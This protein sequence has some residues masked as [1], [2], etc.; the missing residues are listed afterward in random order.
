MQW[1]PG[2]FRFEAVAQASSLV[3]CA[4]KTSKRGRLLHE[5]MYFPDCPSVL[6]IRFRHGSLIL[7]IGIPEPIE[8]SADGRQVIDV[9]RVVGHLQLR[10]D[11]GHI[12]RGV[13]VGDPLGEHRAE[14]VALLGQRHRAVDEDVFARSKRD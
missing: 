2:A 13:A 1:I 8:V 6:Q 3:H 14:C 9:G 10:A 7:R 5:K 4:Q 12:A 11:V